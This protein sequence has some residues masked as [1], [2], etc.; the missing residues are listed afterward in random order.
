MASD[1]LEI[2][3]QLYY[4][5]TKATIERDILRAVELLKAMPG[6]EERDRAQVYMQGLA[7]MRR[8]WA[9][10]RGAS[11][12]ARGQNRPKAQGQGPKFKP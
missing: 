12:R 9:A 3:K 2:I 4:R 8:E 6:E 5:T 10:A 7:E 11:G 1:P